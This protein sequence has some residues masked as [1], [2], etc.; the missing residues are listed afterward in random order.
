MRKVFLDGVDVDR[1]NRHNLISW[2]QS[3]L[4]NPN[5]M[6]IYYQP[7]EFFFGHDV[8]DT[9][10]RLIQET[11]SATNKRFVYGTHE[12]SR[13]NYINDGL[14]N[15]RYDD[16]TCWGESFCALSADIIN[17]HNHEYCDRPNHPRLGN[18]WLG[19]YI[20]LMNR[21]RPHRKITMTQIL[22]H[23]PGLEHGMVT[24]AS[25]DT[26]YGEHVTDTDTEFRQLLMPWESILRPQHQPGQSL[27]YN[28][29]PDRYTHYWFDIVSETSDEIMF[30]T[31]KTWRSI[32]CGKPFVILGAPHQNQILTQ[33]G[34]E[35]FPEIIDYDLDKLN[36]EANDF[37]YRSWIKSITDLSYSDIREL[38]NLF[39]SRYR[40][41]YD[42]WEYMVC[43]DDHIPELF[44]EEIFCGDEFFIN[45][46]NIEDSRSIIR[47]HRQN[48]DFDRGIY[49]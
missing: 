44:R 11:K 7:T 1:P 24:W 18:P 35:L 30:F 38:D 45:Y 33:W 39:L 28:N 3:V 27:N 47:S 8:C 43:S 48:Q 12:H 29:L 4:D 22:R 36:T 37:K 15:R 31:E 34:F 14:I 32:V 21:P 13:G 10:S 6:H 19:K 17:H 23:D 16:I 46:H 25:H 41:N 49:I 20:C 42:I 2:L 26:Q 9:A 5:D 40:W